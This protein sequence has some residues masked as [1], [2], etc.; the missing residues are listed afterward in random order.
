M[1]HTGAPTAGSVILAG[2]LLSMGTYRFLR[3]SLL[4]LP[5]GMRLFLKSMLVVSAQAI[6]Y[7]VY[8]TLIQ[9][10]R[11]QT[12]HILLERQ[13]HGLRDVGDLYAY[14][15]GAEGAVLQMINHGSCRP[16]CFCGWA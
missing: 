4:I 10:D 3:V 11:R 13:P 5:Y 8:V 2:I 14:R 15:S 1:A 9:T 12:P 7:S 6:A 16:R